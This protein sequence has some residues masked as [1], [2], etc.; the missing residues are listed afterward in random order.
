[1]DLKEN[2][3]LVGQLLDNP[4]SKAVFTRRFGKFMRHPLVSAARSLTLAQLCEMAGV[5]LPKKTI[6][7][8]LQE[9]KKL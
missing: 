3:I 6:E 4:A 1:M 8:T 7:D 9:L 2:Q 5:Y